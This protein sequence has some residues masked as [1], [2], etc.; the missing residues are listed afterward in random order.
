MT[1]QLRML[2][3]QP[4]YFHEYSVPL[5]D[6]ESTYAETKVWMILVMFEGLFCY[7]SSFFRICPAGPSV[8]DS[9][10]HMMEMQPEHIISLKRRRKNLE[11]VS[12]ELPIGNCDQ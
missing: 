12:V 4:V 7:D 9:L 6:T 5:R 2:T 10:F 1:L 8:V 3:E 11:F